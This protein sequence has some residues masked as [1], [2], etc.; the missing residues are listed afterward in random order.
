MSTSRNGN[1]SFKIVRTRDKRSEPGN[2]PPEGISEFVEFMVFKHDE[3]GSTR[4]DTDNTGTEPLQKN[5]GKCRD[6]KD[7]VKNFERLV[8]GKTHNHGRAK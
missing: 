8:S 3:N 1:L 7:I 4:D 5:S 2:T 6:I